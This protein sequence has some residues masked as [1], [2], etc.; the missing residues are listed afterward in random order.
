MK[1]TK[2]SIIIPV[3]NEKD[4]ILILL[5][6]VEEVKLPINKDIIIVD[7]FSTDGTRE[8]LKNFENKYS[9]I[10]HNKNKGKGAAVLTALSY[11]TGEIILIQDADLEYDPKDYIKLLN[12]ILEGKSEV[13][14][15]SRVLNKMNNNWT[16]P[17]LYIGSRLITVLAFLL[18]FE[19]ISDVTT[20]YKAFTKE[21]SDK[22]NLKSN[23]FEF[24][25][26]ITAKILKLK[27]KIREI[28][29]N[30]YPRSYSE[31]KKV[32]SKDGFKSVYTLI[33]YRFKNLLNWF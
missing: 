18:Y 30:Y 4:T 8:L 20:C 11:I 3:Y 2:L 9:I 26:E 15:G 27:Y 32:S 19:W 6:K 25:A 33:K 29:I 7:D 12:P 1:Y 14:Y 31:G 17:Q 16:H 5:S 23:G 22:L 13:V 28:P 10:Y 24:D 21:V